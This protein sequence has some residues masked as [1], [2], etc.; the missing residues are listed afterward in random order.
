MSLINWNES[1]SVKVHEID[2]QHQKLVKLILNGPPTPCIRARA[3]TSSA[4]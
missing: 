1:M 2:V 3:R 4:S